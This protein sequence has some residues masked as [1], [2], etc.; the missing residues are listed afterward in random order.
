ML[1]TEDPGRTAHSNKPR[2][3]ALTQMMTQSTSTDGNGARPLRT[4][5][6]GAASGPMPQ[7]DPAPTTGGPSRLSCHARGRGRK[8]T[9]TTTTRKKP[10]QQR[11]FQVMHWNAESILN[12]KTELEHILHEKNINICCIQE[13]HLTPQKSFKVRGYQCLRSDRTDRSKGGILTLIRNNIN[14]CLIETHMED[15]EYQVIRIQTK[16]SEF[17]LVNFYCPN[18]RHLALDTIPAKASNFIVVGD[19]NSHSQSWGYDH[20]DRRGEE[21]ENWQDDKG[22]ILLNSPFDCPTFYSRRWHTTSTPDLAF[23]TEDMHQL[24]SREVGEQLGGS[25][26]RPVFLTLGMESCTEASFPRWNYKRANWFLFRHRT[27][28]LTKDI[29]VEGRD[30]NMVAKDF[31]M[32]ILR[33]ARESIPRGARRDYKPY[34][35]NELQELDDDL[36]DARREAEVNPSQNNNIRLQEAK[37][38]FLKKKLQARRRSWQ[39]KTSSLNLEKDGRKLWRLTKQLNDE[40]TSRGKITLEENGKVL[41]G[42]HAANQFAESYAAE[43][44][45]HVSPEKQREARREKRERPARQSTVDAMSQPLTLHELRSALKKSKAKKSPGPDGITNEMLTHLGSAAENKLLEV[46]NSSWQEGSLPQL[47]REAIM[48]PI[49]KKGKDP[50]KA[51]SYRP[52]SLTSCV[53]KTLER[54]VNE[55]LRWYLESRNLLAP[56][57]AGFRQFRSTEDQVTY[58]A[59][60]VEDAF[61]EQKLVFVTWIDLQKAFDKVWKDGLLVKLLRKGVSSNMYQWI[62]SYLYNRRA[63]VNVDQTKSK[64]FLLRHGVPQGGVLSPTLF[65]LF[66]DDL[67]S[68]MPKG[69]KAALYAD[70]LVIWCKEEH[71]S[72]ATYRMQ[73]AADRLNAWAEDWCVSINKEKSSTTLFTLSPKQKAGTIRLGG[74]PLRE[75]EEATYLGVTFDRRQT[76]K[77]HIAQAETK[78]RRKLAILR[79]LAGTTWGA[80]EKILKTVYQGTI[81]PHLEYGSTAWSTSA[82]TNLQ[83][84]DR[85]QNQA[86]RLITG[87]MKSTPIKEMEKLTTIQPLCQRREAKTMVQAEKLKCL[88][89]HPMKHRL[90]NLTKNRLKRSSFVHESKRL[91]RQY[92]EVLPQ[93]TLPLTQEEEETPKATEK[94]GIQ[95]C[96]SVPH[97]TSGEDQNDTA[98]Q[99]LTLALIDEQYPKEAWIHV[100]TDGSATNAVL[101]GGAGILIQFPGGHTATSSVA[102]GKHC[103]NYK[104]EAEALMQ[105]ASLVQDSADPCYQVV[106]LSDALSVLQALENDKLPQL[107]KALQMVRQTRRVVLQWIPA[108]CGI[109]GNERADEL[110]KEGAVEDQPENSVSFSEQ[111]TIIKAL[112]RPRTNRD[113]YHTMSREQQVNLIRLRTGHN[114]LNAHMNRKFKLAPSPTCACGQE[115]QTAEHILQRCPLLDEERKEVWPS[116]TPLQTK[117]YGSRQELEKTTTFITSAGL[118]V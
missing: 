10:S 54:I 2:V 6:G 103:T 8:V 60:E 77:P 73:Q 74:T 91:S 4:P 39:E 88:P 3:H 82:K 108:H 1:K 79:K 78:A 28:E 38:K 109:P 106:F 56:E 98:R 12:K 59:Q 69:I 66:I 15:S 116:P 104:A 47:W 9:G 65:L 33:A 72:T 19:F 11:P 49:L 23:C 34:W 52:I 76:W 50:K 102:T 35:S 71:A 20:L 41:T 93:N 44:N 92:R 62:R 111:K 42:K 81:R 61:Q 17:H 14:A 7:R 87:A 48:I 24:T 32:S 30:I 45:L 114:R 101:N 27:S 75:D 53:V 110:A 31:N 43:S 16:T 107:A 21:V 99:A 83:T 115:D 18:D 100:Y 70:D 68:E 29:R 117:L 80:N 95:I 37:A 64:K 51:T 118:I 94:P 57:Q 25:D 96:T 113:D 22:L 58:L 5:Q 13:T 97:V 89:D 84:L 55:R 63:R 36:A 46:F 26:H 86:L 40:N 105:A 85:V 67:V 90:S 112:M